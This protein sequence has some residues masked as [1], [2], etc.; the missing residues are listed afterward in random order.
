LDADLERFPGGLSTTVRHL[1]EE[2]GIR[3][4]GVWQAI[5]G[6][7]NGIDPNSEAF[8]EF[9]EDLEVLPSGKVLPCAD[10]AHCF[11][12]WNKWHQYLKHCGI[13]FVK[14]DSQSSISIFQ[15]GRRNF[16]EA[17]R[18]IHTGLEASTALN[19]DGSLINCMG[20]APEDIWNRPQATLSRNSD[21]FV[22][23]VPHAIRENALQNAYNSLL[24][25]NFYW[26]DWDMFWSGHEAAKQNAI[27]RALS[28]GPIY[29]SEPIGKANP[30]YIFPLVMDEGRILRCSGVGLPT[31]DCLFSDPVKGT[32][33]LKIFNHFGNDYAVGVFNISES[34]QV[35]HAEISASDI[36]ELQG[37]TV[38]IYDWQTVPLRY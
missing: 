37:K 15:T 38:W 9:S 28:G 22:P 26:E 11:G 1:K 13:D 24:H 21:D 25:G 14:V 23:K 32:V 2:H 8:R 12:F 5:M 6:Y 17:S 34:E 16:G 4:V 31:R 27:L 36:P 29:L 20:M 19:F 7:W 10:T 33:P 30:E 3:W 35:C 18:G